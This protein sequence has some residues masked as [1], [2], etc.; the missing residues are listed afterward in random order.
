MIHVTGGLDAISKAV[1]EAQRGLL[2]AEPTIVV[3]QPLTVDPSRA[4][5]GAGM[6][7]VQL[8]EL[9]WRV[10]GDAAGTLDVGDGTW[11][12]SL[13]ERYAQR[14]HEQLRR[15]IANLDSATLARTAL[16]PADLQAANINLVRGDPYSGSTTIDQSLFLRP[17]ARN[18][19]HRTGIDRLWHIGASSHPGPGLS[20]MS[21]FL[22]AGALTRSG[23][24]RPRGRDGHG[25]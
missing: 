14:V 2:P 20:G 13:R 5:A 15:H 19:G 8:A 9:P 10:R 7:W 17:F 16:S 24:R 6:L 18:A 11:T 4:P 3:G 22:A 12:E 21:G 1:N 23:P 25:G